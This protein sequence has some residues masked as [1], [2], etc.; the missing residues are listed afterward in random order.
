MRE[1]VDTWE[2]EGMVGMLSMPRCFEA[3]FCLLFVLL[4]VGHFE[5]ARRCTLIVFKL[6]PDNFINNILHLSLGTSGSIEATASSTPLYTTVGCDSACN[7]ASGR[8][9]STYAT[10]TAL[11]FVRAQVIPTARAFEGYCHAAL[12]VSG[13]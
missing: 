1:Q 2:Q 11:F 7:V 6:L 5:H 4:K 8:W 12:P 3:A 10:R 13:A 9:H